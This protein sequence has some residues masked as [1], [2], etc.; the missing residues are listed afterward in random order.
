MITNQTD[1]TE[2]LVKVISKKFCEENLTKIED[3]KM[4]EMILWKFAVIHLKIVREATMKIFQ[5]V[6]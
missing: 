5:G 4:V 6:K 1:Q 2:E 3:I